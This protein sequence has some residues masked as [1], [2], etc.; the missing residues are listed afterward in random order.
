MK[1]DPRFA[2]QNQEF[3]ALVKL[4]SERMGYSERRTK[5]LPAT[6]MRRHSA[7]AIQGLADANGWDVSS[8]T[9]AQAALYIAYRADTLEKLVKPALMNKTQAARACRRLQKSR[10]SW[11]GA[12]LPNNKQGAEEKNFLSS[13]VSMIAVREL[14]GREFVA[15]PTALVSVSDGG[16]LVHALPRQMDGAYPSLADPVAV[17]EVKEYYGTTTFGSRVSDGVYETR[18]DGLEIAK[19]KAEGHMIRNYL[20]VDDYFT[21]WEKGRSYLCRIVDMLN[22]GLINGAFFG[23]QVLTE[24]AEEV[25]DFRLPA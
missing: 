22:E 5:A 20:M 12:Y 18:L 16:R 24:W 7:A 21:W 9:V 4:A 6:G 19:V 10:D 13:M 23:R 15:N 8:A 1:A 11:T 2:N 25:R 14:A 17:W 3:W